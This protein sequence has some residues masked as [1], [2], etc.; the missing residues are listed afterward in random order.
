MI[1]ITVDTLWLGKVGVRD[2][3]IDEANAKNEGLTVNHKGKV[4][5]VPFENLKR[6]ILFKSPKPFKDKYSNKSHYLY[7]LHFK[8]D[9]KRLESEPK[10]EKLL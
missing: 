3:Y 7:Y 5:T 9:S 10:Q 2:K 1:K 4:M 8:V 6:S